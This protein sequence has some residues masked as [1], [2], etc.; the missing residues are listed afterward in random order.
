MPEAEMQR[1][2]AAHG[3]SHDMRALNPEM[4]ENRADVVRGAAL[5]IVGLVLRHVG[6]RITTRVERNAAIALAEMPH[7]RLPA[8]GIAGELMH[9]DQRLSGTCLLVV[10]ADSVISR[11]VR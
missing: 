9:E 6:G 5:R 2:K 11:G 4:I 8:A 10:Q 7:L 3:Q 1:G